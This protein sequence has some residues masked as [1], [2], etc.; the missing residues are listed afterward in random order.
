MAGGVIYSDRADYHLTQVRVILLFT[1]TKASGT[2]VH[3]T[4]HDTIPPSSCMPTS[5][6]TRS[7]RE[8]R[9]ACTL[10]GYN[11]TRRPNWLCAVVCLVVLVLGWNLDAVLSPC[12]QR[13]VRLPMGDYPVTQATHVRDLSSCPRN[14]ESN[15]LQ[16]NDTKAVGSDNQSTY[17]TSKPC[18]LWRYWGS[19]NGWVKTVSHNNL[20]N[21]LWHR[22]H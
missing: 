15:T 10:G 3:A 8:R 1:A 22:L 16:H 20:P 5:T 9:T 21:L 13:L 2:I 4:V 19:A 12:W 11:C 18:Y 7:T 6:C 14:P 17:H